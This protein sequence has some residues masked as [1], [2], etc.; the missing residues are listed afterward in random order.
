VGYGLGVD[1][2]TSFTGV[3]IARHGRTRIVTL[4]DDPISVSSFVAVR[5]PG[6]LLVREVDDSVPVSPVASAPR[7]VPVED[8]PVSAPPSVPVETATAAQRLLGKIGERQATYLQNQQ[9]LE[10]MCRTGTVGVDRDN[11]VIT[12]LAQADVRRQIVAGVV[13][14][15]QGS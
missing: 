1:L 10:T 14:R 12:A 7:Q 13:A 2:G 4:S 6:S 8:A 15:Q 11:G 3:A 5:A 9:V